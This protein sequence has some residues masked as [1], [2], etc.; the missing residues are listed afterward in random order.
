MLPS[1]THSCSP[2]LLLHPKSSRSDLTGSRGSGLDLPSST[3]PGRQVS[4]PGREGSL[5][6][7]ARCGPLGR[8]L[9]AAALP[10][11][12]VGLVLCLSLGSQPE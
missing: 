10:G 1:R 4:L 12:G 8:G 11:V 2:G 9:A 3:T 7:P 5:L 6:R